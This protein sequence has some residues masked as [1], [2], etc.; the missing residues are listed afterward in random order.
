M[1]EGIGAVTDRVGFKKENKDG[2]EIV[3]ST[4]QKGLETFVFK[5]D[6]TNPI[7]PLIN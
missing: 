6:R 2:K 5:T 1:A 3:G 4:I 7:S